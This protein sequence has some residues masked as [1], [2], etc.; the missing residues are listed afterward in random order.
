MNERIER[1]PSFCQVDKIR[2]FIHD[3]EDITEGNQKWHGAIPSFNKIAV[4]MM[5]DGCIIID[6]IHMV[7]EA[8]RIRLL[9][10]AWIKKYLVVAS[11]S[12]NLFEFNMSGINLIKLISNPHHRNSQF[13]LDI[14][15]N[16]LRIRIEDEIAWNEREKIGCIKDLMESNHQ[17]KVRSFYFCQK[18]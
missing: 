14:I 9:P 2:Q 7:V 10:S 12:W 3:N 5:Y 8:I 15:I 6:G 17:L 18:S 13:L 16:V 11:F 1:G 4:M